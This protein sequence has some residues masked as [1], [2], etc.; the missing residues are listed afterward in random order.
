[1]L[2]E[3][4]ARPPRTR[5]THP[6]Y[7]RARRQPPAAARRKGQGQWVR[8]ALGRRCWQSSAAHPTPAAPPPPAIVAAATR[9]T[10]RG[11]CVA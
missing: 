7:P 11:H 3:R 10:G 2:G 5:R 9:C 4:I 1:L 6:A 8:A